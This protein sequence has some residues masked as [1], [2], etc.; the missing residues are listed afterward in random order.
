MASAPDL[1]TLLAVPLPERLVCSA[2]A[3]VALGFGEPALSPSIQG[4]RLG[5]AAGVYVL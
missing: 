1:K 3:C 4:C 2:G 5:G